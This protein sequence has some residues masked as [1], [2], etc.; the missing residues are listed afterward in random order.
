M[1]D[2]MIVLVALG[3]VTL[4]FFAGATGVVLRR[5]LALWRWRQGHPSRIPLKFAVSMK[6]AQ[7]VA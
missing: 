3:C 5:E 1:I 6:K 7:R 2:M 4:L